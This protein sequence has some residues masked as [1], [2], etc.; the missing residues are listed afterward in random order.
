M[1]RAAGCVCVWDKRGKAERHGVLQLLTVLGTSNINSSW[2][3]NNNENCNNHGIFLNCNK[4]LIKPKMKPKN[5]IL[6]FSTTVW[7]NIFPSFRQIAGL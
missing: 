3:Y 6:F 5:L 4:L 7:K 2:F 1:F